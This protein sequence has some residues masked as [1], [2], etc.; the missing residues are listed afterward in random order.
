MNILIVEDEVIVALDLAYLLEGLGHSVTALCASVDAAFQAMEDRTVDFAI[1]DFSL[2]DETSAPVADALTEKGVP[3]VFLTA[4]RPESL[5]P[6]F[7]DCTVLSK[8]LQ[9]RRLKE[10]LGVAS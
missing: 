5:P 9:T 2:R 3:F 6:R 7:G 1:L 10:A 8:P 4:Y